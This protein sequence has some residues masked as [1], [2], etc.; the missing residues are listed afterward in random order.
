MQLSAPGGT[1]TSWYFRGGGKMI[2]TSFLPTIKK[3]L[4]LSKIPGEH[5]H[6]F[7]PLVAGLEP[8]VPR[9]KGKTIINLFRAMWS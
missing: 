4:A 8:G 9:R 5:L 7:S 6:G 1:A 3:V 2:E